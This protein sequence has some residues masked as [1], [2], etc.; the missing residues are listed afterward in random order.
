MNAKCQEILKLNIKIIY[1]PK[2][3]FLKLIFEGKLNIINLKYKMVVKIDSISTLSF[4]FSLVKGP[5]FSSKQSH[6]VEPVVH[7]I[8]RFVKTNLRTLLFT[9]II[10][11]LY[12][13]CKISSHQV[14][15]IRLQKIQ[16]S[17]IFIKFQ[18]E[19]KL[20]NKMKIY[21]KSQT[22]RK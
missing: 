20:N 21:N 16:Y 13:N 19:K 10:L 4:N 12:A 5:K 3:D 7:V 17:N 22:F 6:H 14:I 8:K 2:A 1:C 18:N 15:L 9:N 11:K